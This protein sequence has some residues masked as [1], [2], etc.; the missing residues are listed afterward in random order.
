MRSPT[1][2]VV[3]PTYNQL[4]QLQRA[5]GSILAQTRQPDEI[6]VIDDGCTDGSLEWLQGMAKKD[7]RFQVFSNGTN[8]GAVYS[9]NQCYA[10]AT[11]D[12]IFGLPSDDALMPDGLETLCRAFDAHPGEAVYCGDYVMADEATGKLELYN[13]RWSTEIRRFGPDEFA[14]VLQ[15]WWVPS[16]ACLVQNKA[17]R[18]VGGLREDLRWHSDWF[19]FLAIALRHGLCAVPEVVIVR[20]RHGDSYATSRKDWSK[21]APVLRTLLHTLKSPEFRDVLPRFVRSGAM[22]FFNRELDRLV[23]SEPEFWS[24]PEVLMLAQLPMWFRMMACK[25]NNDTIWDSRFS[26]DPVLGRAKKAL[27]G[28]PGTRT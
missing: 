22:L 9:G 6:V 18:E 20:R 15:G 4:A 27:D 26:E 2:S 3:M 21:Q 1:I 14:E 28:M 13:N 24:D 11:C 25:K 5:I 7:S 17:I 8:R 12:Y 16:F 19:A 10:R 23:M